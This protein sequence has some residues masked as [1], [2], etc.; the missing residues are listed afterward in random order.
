MWEEFSLFFW[1]I[2]PSDGG[3]IVQATQRIILE[4]DWFIV[5]LP[6]KGQSLSHDT[7]PSKVD[8]LSS[9]VF[10][11]KHSLAF[12]LYENHLHFWS[13]LQFIEQQVE[14]G[15]SASSELNCISVPCEWLKSAAFM[16][17]IIIKLWTEFLE[18]RWSSVSFY[19]RS[20]TIFLNLFDHVQVQQ[21]LEIRGL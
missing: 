11:K 20:H 18:V 17:R 8:N 14:S 3:T 5:S 4:I 2:G 9:Q 7:N 13:A 21:G 16:V 10:H 1:N 12:L 15:Q 6:I 19:T